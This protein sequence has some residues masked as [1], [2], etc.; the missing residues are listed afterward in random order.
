[1][2]YF[3][4]SSP[5]FNLKPDQQTIEDARENPEDRATKRCKRQTVAPLKDALN[6]LNGNWVSF[7]I[8]DML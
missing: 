5:I 4:G 8:G 7:K 1:M 3:F 2:D 6:I